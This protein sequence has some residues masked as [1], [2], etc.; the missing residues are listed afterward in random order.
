[1]AWL[2]RRAMEIRRETK[3][4]QNTILRWQVGCWAIV[5]FCLS[6]IPPNAHSW[7]MIWA[8]PLVALV[9]VDRIRFADSPTGGRFLP[10][11]RWPSRSVQVMLFLFYG[12]SFASFYIY[13]TF[14]R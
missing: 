11:V 5:M 13:H 10:N 3:L 4:D 14:Y 12:W 2:F 7:Y 8:I 9:T 6:Y 1:M